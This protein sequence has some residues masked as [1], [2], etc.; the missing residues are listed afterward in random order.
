[1]L[2]PSAT[3]NCLYAHAHVWHLHVRHRQISESIKHNPCHAPATA[4]QAA[5][6]GRLSVQGRAQRRRGKVEP[7]PTSG[8]VQVSSC[9]PLRLAN[10]NHFLQP[11][12]HTLPSRRAGPL[13]QG[14]ISLRALEQEFLNTFYWQS[15]AGDRVA[16]PRPEA[17]PDK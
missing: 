9:R 12:L 10:W 14:I 15:Q 11:F 4:G 1:M 16:G 6:L 17:A 7:W 5:L 2:I 3:I 8:L 13:R